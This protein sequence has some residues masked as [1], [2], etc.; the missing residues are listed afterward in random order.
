MEALVQPFVGGIAMASGSESAP[1]KG[2][3]RW[4]VCPT[5]DMVQALLETLV[6]PLLPLRVSSVPPSEDV[7]IAVAKQIHAVVL[8]YN[9]HHRKQKQELVFLEFVDFCK[10]AIVIRPPLIAFMMMTKESEPQVMYDTE[11][12]LSITERAIKSACDIALGLDASRDFPKMEGWPVSKL[13]VLLI[14]SKKE[15]CILQSGAVTEGALSLQKEL[16]VSIIPPELSAGNKVGNKRRRDNLLTYSNTEFLQ[17]GYDVV[18]DVTGISSSELEVLETHVTYSLSKEKSAA[19]FYIMQFPGSFDGHK[20]VPLKFLFE[21]VQG[22]LAEKCANGS[23]KTTPLIKLYHMLPYMGIIWCWLSRLEMGVNSSDQKAGQNH[24]NNNKFFNSSPGQVASPIDIF[25]GTE[26][27]VNLTSEFIKRFEILDSAESNQNGVLENL[28]DGS[29]QPGKGLSSSPSRGLYEMPIKVN[30]AMEEIEKGCDIADPTTEVASTILEKA[31]AVSDDPVTDPS[32]RLF[33]K[34]AVDDS[35]REKFKEKPF[36][37]SGKNNEGRIC[38]ENLDEELVECCKVIL[39]SPPRLL[40]TTNRNDLSDTCTD[41]ED[42][43]MQNTKIRVYFH[44]RKKNTVLLQEAVP[45]LK[46]DMAGSLQSNLTKKRDEKVCGVEGNL[47]KTCNQTGSTSSGDQ[48]AQLEAKTKHTVEVQGTLDSF[49]SNQPQRRYEKVSGDEGYL[50]TADNQTGAASTKNQRAQLQVCNHTGIAAKENQLV[51]FQDNCMLNLGAQTTPALDEMHSAL[52][53]INRKRQELYFQLCN[54]VDELAL[55]EDI[56]DRILGG[57][58]DLARQCINSI[59]SGKFHSLVENR[60]QVHR[61]GNQ[62]DETRISQHGNPTR[63]SKVYLPGKSSC[64]DLEYTCQRNDLREPRYS[65]QFSDG[66]YLSTVVVTGKDFE[67]HA[68]GGV[69]SHPRTARE[70]AAAKMIAE[71]LHTWFSTLAT[72]E[73]TKVQPEQELSIGTP[74][75]KETTSK[76]PKNTRPKRK[77]MQLAKTSTPMQDGLADAQPT[78]K[79]YTI[80]DKALKTYPKRKSARPA[81]Y[82]DFSFH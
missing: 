43:K 19:W 34:T 36:G 64:Q 23:W 6:D 18:K 73:P 80:E 62:P 1:E 45:D 37:D 69:E 35:L 13:T 82:K 30:N 74:A 28:A 5:E 33:G 77:A 57:D 66:G 53:L 55:C 3:L 44:K 63:L 32:S 81:K 10:L 56:F 76:G 9:Y 31:D 51:L 65:I 12:L 16:S 59:I 54:T 22:P 68:K 46:E 20:Q 75:V 27:Y 48:R 60:T 71:M 47:T 14:D 4:A 58:I 25:Q 24:Y 38:P 61:N 50:A 49:R 78:P 67:L 41:S 17:L 39:A 8:L 72:V 42:N 11:D 70:T 15:N 26:R 21:S 52:T 2:G 40:N 79:P 7:Q 29:E